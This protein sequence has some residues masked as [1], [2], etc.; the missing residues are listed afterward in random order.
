MINPLLAATLSLALLAGGARAAF[1]ETGSGARAPGM[2]DAFTALADDAYSIHYNPAGLAQVDRPQFGAA[3]SR[4]YVGLSD[5]SE[6]GSSQLVYAHPLS[7]GKRGTL[8]LG[9]DRLSLGG[10][11]SESTLTLSYGRRVLARES[12]SQLLAGINFKQLSHSFGRAA[13]ATNACQDLD[14]SKGADPLLSG[15]NTKSAFDGDLGLIYRFPRRFQLGLSVKHLLSPNVAFSG[16]DKVERAIDAGL[17]YKSLWLSLAGEL[18]LHKSASGG[19]QRDMIF[20]AERFFPTLDYGQFGLRGALGIGTADWRQITFG[21]SYR[22]NKIQFDYAFLLPVGGVKGQSGSHRM[23]LTFHFGAP[24]GDEEMSRDILE[25]AQK[26]RERGPDYGYEYSE[27]LKPQSLDDPR[28]AEVRALILQRRYRPAQKV[29]TEFAKNQPLSPPLIRLSNRLGMVVSHY[30]DLPEPKSKFDLTLV[31]GLNRF[32]FGEDRLAM[33]QTSY[34]YSL[35]A[36]DIRLNKFLEDMEQGLG[37]KAERMPPNH[38]RSF[39][40]EL[41]YRVEFANTRGET[42]KVEALLSDILVLEPEHVTALERLGSLRYV[43][44]RNLE[45]IKAWEAALKLETRESELESLREYMR[46]ARERVSGK[47]LPGEMPPAAIVPAVPAPPL[48]RVPVVPREESA[49]RRAA[50]AVSGD[51]RDV[52]QLYQKGVEFY[53]RGEYLQASSMFMRI[54]RIDPDNEQARKALER[55]DRRKPKR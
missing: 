29:L 9:W 25:Q 55:I 5:G 3:Y 34:A 27:E 46:L 45:A 22:V 48:A 36:E 40:E 43:T 38:P 20:A 51:P 7:H 14:C 54:L 47:A 13:E 23:A 32:L 50:P 37:I 8:G 4:L 39:M 6:I 49:A 44:G 31:A 19:M 16:S 52:S 24:T 10:L 17:A 33:L 30:A 35:K 12:G 26:L 18:K 53:A 42:G 15:S 41:L 11:Y 21:S 28:L 2:G 1:E